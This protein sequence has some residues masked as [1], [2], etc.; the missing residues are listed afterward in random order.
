MIPIWQAVARGT[1]HPS[2]FSRSGHGIWDSIK[3]EVVEYGG[4]NLVSRNTP[5]NVGTPECGRDCYPEL[6]RSTMYPPGPAYA[7][8]AVGTSYATPKV[9]RI[10]AQLQSVLPKESCLLYRALIVQSARWPNWALDAKR[11]E[12]A[13]IIRWIGYGIPN[14]DRA[15]SNTEYRT[16][17]ISSGDRQLNARGCHIYQIPIDKEMR[18]PGHDYDVLI[19]V[20]LSYSAQPRRTRRNRR[21]YLSVWLDWKSSNLG[22]PLNAF[23]QR[24]I[25]MDEKSEA[26]GDSL[27]WTINTNPGWGSVRGVSRSAGTVQKDWA[28]VKSNV[29]PEDFCIAVVGHP[30]WSKDP[31][32]VAIYTLAVSV[33]MIGKEIPIYEKL[34][35]SVENLEAQIMAEAEV[36][37]IM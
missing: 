11:E 33:E 4:D 9:S 37:T 10:A 17:L 22:E 6:V 30:G 24:A 15:V 14:M 19:E 35:L 8:D 20:T 3:P 36:E 7:R 27:P 26:E 1:G 25:V 28:I 31:D 12:Q 32:S 21:H 23:Q 18:R 29:L 13:N 16:T 5:E 34:R 2:A